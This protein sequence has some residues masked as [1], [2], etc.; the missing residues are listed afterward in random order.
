LNEHGHGFGNGV[1]Y[2]IR[3]IATGLSHIGLKKVLKHE[4]PR[5]V[6]AV[7]LA[8]N[9]REYLSGVD[10]ELRFVYDDV[11]NPSEETEGV[12]RF[13]QERWFTMRAKK[14]RILKKVEA[15]DSLRVSEFIDD[16][17]PLFDQKKSPSQ[18]LAVQ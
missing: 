10:D 15:S 5:L 3:S 9:C 16:S 13:W 1:N 12:V 4:N 17:P 11:E 8:E 2:K 18:I 6:Y 7:P 14:P